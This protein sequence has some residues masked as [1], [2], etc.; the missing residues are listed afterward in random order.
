M[1]FAILCGV[2][3]SDC[4]AKKPTKREQKRADFEAQLMQFRKE[5]EEQLERER[6]SVVY[7][8]TIR[9]DSIEVPVYIDYNHHM[10]MPQ[11]YYS[12][13]I[14]YMQFAFGDTD[15]DKYYCAYGMGE[16]EAYAEAKHIALINAVR[17][18]REEAGD[19]VNLNSVELLMVEEDKI[20]EKYK[21]LIKV[22]KE[23][24]LQEGDTSALTFIQE[25][26]DIHKVEVAI[27]IPKNQ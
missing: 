1:L 19:G 8:D 6:N 23:E 21:E 26:E 4:S 14:M 9:F 16:A 12:N 15:K 20:R 13:P 25:N 22:I 17:K 11:I 24:L 3:Y 5:Q 18:I 2:V 10:L 7:I 27:R